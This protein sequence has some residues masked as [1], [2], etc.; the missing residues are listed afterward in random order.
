[1]DQGV[2]LLGGQA[3]V[4]TIVLHGGQ[5]LKLDIAV[6]R[7]TA[8]DL[9]L[10]RG[11]SLTAELLDLAFPQLQKVLAGDVL[12]RTKLLLVGVGDVAPDRPLG[13][14]LALATTFRRRCHVLP[15]R[16]IRVGCVSGG[17]AF[18]L[19]MHHVEFGRGRLTPKLG[20]EFVTFRLQLA[21]RR[22]CIGLRI[23]DIAGPAI[24]AELSGGKLEQSLVTAGLI[25][26]IAA[27]LDLGI[28]PHQCGVD[29]V[30]R[31]GTVN[32]GI[33]LLVEP[34][35]CA[36]HRPRACCRLVRQARLFLRRSRRPRSGLVRIA[37]L[38]QDFP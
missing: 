35:P 8:C 12:D 7:T 23:E 37:E 10:S 31:R 34:W 33:D 14:C 20:C 21:G 26:W 1:M 19:L 11:T 28:G 2:A 24:L 15:G 29:A 32:D 13:P 38:L 4:E 30:F 25:R 5:V 3:R 16:R 18:A 17:P 9:A 36:Q 27:A 6:T 22:L